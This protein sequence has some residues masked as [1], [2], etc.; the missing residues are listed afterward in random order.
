MCDVEFVMSSVRCRY[1]I[2]GGVGVGWGKGRGQV[3]LNFFKALMVKFL[4]IASVNW[5]ISSLTPKESNR[6]L[7]DKK[8]S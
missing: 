5:Y 6:P 8:N 7:I 2:S 1:Q 4:E 3:S